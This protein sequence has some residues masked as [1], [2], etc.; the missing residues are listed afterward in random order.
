MGW[1]IDL[2]AMNQRWQPRVW[3]E[4]IKFLYDRVATKATF[5]EGPYLRYPFCLQQ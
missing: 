1:G 5:A 4:P 3:D 2:S